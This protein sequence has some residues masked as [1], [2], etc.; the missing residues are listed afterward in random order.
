MIEIPS[1]KG[2][3]FIKLITY[4]EKNTV[5]I[6]NIC[7]EI[8]TGAN[9]D[10]ARGIRKISMLGGTTIAQQPETADYPEMRA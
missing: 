9:K 4:Q 5:L 2:K 6:K 7:A 3:M 10:G 1:F 8:L